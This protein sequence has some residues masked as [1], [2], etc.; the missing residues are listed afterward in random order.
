M[1]IISGGCVVPS[2][3][4]NASRRPKVT[5]RPDDAY[6][7]M[8]LCRA[9]SALHGA[10]RYQMW[11]LWSIQGDMWR[12]FSC[13]RPQLSGECTHLRAHIS[14]LNCACTRVLTRKTRIGS[15]PMTWSTGFL[16]YFFYY[17][18]GDDRLEC[19]P[20][21]TA[22]VFNPIIPSTGKRIIRQRIDHVRI[23]IQ[24]MCVRVGHI[25]MKIDPKNKL[26]KKGL[27]PSHEPAFGWC[28][29]RPI[30]DVLRL[31]CLIC[32]QRTR[33]LIAEAFVAFAN[34]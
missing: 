7:D 12:I 14:W 4:P 5:K 25:S 15:C 17:P 13:R 9:V 33:I 11:C 20:S 1:Q 2:A 34:I 29:S 26:F 28:G 16:C 24:P 21:H 31:L 19:P 3:K 6:V 22:R 32:A 18:N 10:R 27:S 8:H 30:W 23:I